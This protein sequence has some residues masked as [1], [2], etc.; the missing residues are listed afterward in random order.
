MESWA[1]V[2]SCDSDSRGR[3]KTIAFSETQVLESS[4]QKSPAA[5]KSFPQSTQGSESLLAGVWEKLKFCF[6]TV[7]S[8]QVN[9][10]LTDASN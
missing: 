10:A 7:P 6:M 4:T 1:Y 9:V 2:F 5:E 3:G 8:N